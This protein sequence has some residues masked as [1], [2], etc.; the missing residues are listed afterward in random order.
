[1]FVVVAQ[2]SK[3]CVL[4]ALLDATWIMLVGLCGSTSCHSIQAALQQ[5]G[6]E[7]K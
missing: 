7:T 3:I 2:F 1:M 5:I 4:G 6:G